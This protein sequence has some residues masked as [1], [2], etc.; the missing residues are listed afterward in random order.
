MVVFETGGVIIN[1]RDICNILSIMLMNQATAVS[2]SPSLSLP[3]S[4]P[5]SLYIS[6]VGE[7]EMSS[8]TVNVRTRD[9]IVHGEKTLKQLLDHMTRLKATRSR[10]DSG[11]F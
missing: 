11:E 3:L 5:P 7:K 2:L 9:N 10:D 6:V 4:L 8:Q 1:F